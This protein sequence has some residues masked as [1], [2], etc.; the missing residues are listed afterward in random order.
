MLQTVKNT[1]KRIIPES[2]LKYY[3]YYRY[4]MQRELKMT[5]AEHYIYRG[6]EGSD[7]VYKLLS[8]NKPCLI[9]RFGWLELETLMT[10]LRNCRKK[11]VSFDADLKKIRCILLRVFSRRRTTRWLASAM[12]F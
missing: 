5:F 1:L 2:V 12:R 4:P 7:L 10:Y 3:Y 6:D 11:R 8:Q 9:G